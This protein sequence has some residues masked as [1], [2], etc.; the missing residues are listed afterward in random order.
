MFLGL[1]E[2]ENLRSKPV[3]MF[4]RLAYK[5]CYIL[6][7]SL[8]GV[9]PHVTLQ[10]LLRPQLLPAHLASKLRGPVHGHVVLDALFRPSVVTLR[11]LAL[12][13]G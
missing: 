11:T 1:E 5:R 9:S 2:N 4:Y 13:I 10:A 7:R 12:G 3:S 8:P 6:V